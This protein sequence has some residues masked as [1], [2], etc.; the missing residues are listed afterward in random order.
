MPIETNAHILGALPEFY[1]MRCTTAKQKERTKEC[2]E[3]AV[4]VDHA[5]ELR[6]LSETPAIDMKRVLQRNQYTHIMA[7]QA[8]VQEIVEEQ[9]KDRDIGRERFYYTRILDEHKKEEEWE[10]LKRKGVIR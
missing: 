5:I 6:A 3:R 7:A 9:A 1:R 2:E 8:K 4:M 10:E